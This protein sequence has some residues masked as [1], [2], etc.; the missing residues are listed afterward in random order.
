MGFGLASGVVACGDDDDGGTPTDTGG[1]STGGTSTAGKSGGGSSAGG[2]SGKAGMGG[3][4]GATGG[5]GGTV[6]GGTAAGG[7]SGSGVG[8][9]SPSGDG[10]VGG[11]SVAGAAGQGGDGAG[12]A[13]PEQPVQVA[14]PQWLSYFCHAISMDELG[15][16]NSTE[17]IDC[18]GPYSHYLPEYGDY[19]PFC[20]GDDPENGD[21]SETE[22]LVALMGAL[23]AACPNP[24]AEDF[25]CSISG[26]PSPKDAACRDAYAAVIANKDQCTPP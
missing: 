22:E 17:W 14:D 7:A 6:S 23:A 19:E 25:S 1:T 9:E 11:D 10:G 4:S 21:I 15:C 26:K 8:G 5:E 12:G 16:T 13:P 24:T 20:V 18:Y 2:S 3:S